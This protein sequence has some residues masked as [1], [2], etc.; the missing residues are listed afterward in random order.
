[1]PK[2]SDDDVPKSSALEDA[3]DRGEIPPPFALTASGRAQAWTGRQIIEHHRQRL[4][5]TT[6]KKSRARA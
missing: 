5:A 4:A 1:M 6:S 2:N 3:I